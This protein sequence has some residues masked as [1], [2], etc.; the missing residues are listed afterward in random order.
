V[1]AVGLII[2]TERPIQ[3]G[4]KL[5]GRHGNKGVVARIISEREMPYFKSSKMG[6]RDRGC[7]LRKQRI[8]HTHLEILLNPLTITGRMNL[9]QL[10]ETILDG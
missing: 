9:G 10:Y 6:C 4:D 1:A 5:T 2:E 8:N 7:D 3:M